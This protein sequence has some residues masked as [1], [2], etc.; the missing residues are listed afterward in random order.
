M[1]PKVKM[2]KADSIIYFK[3]DKADSVF[4]LKSGQVVLEYND[5]QNDEPIKDVINSGEFFGVKS[6]LVKYPR[7]EDAK[8]TADSQIIEFS[9]PDFEA[10]ITKNTSIILKSNNIIWIIIRTTYKPIFTIRY[11]SIISTRNI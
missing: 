4:L 3:G 2:F 8:T 6:G 7:E 10:L 1:A 9:T 11:L 5:I